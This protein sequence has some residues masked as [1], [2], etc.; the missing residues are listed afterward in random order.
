VHTADELVISSEEKG[1]KHILLVKKGDGVML[2]ARFAITAY[3]SAPIVAKAQQPPIEEALALQGEQLAKAS[4]DV[5]LLLDPVEAEALFPNLV[6]VFGLDALA[7][8]L[9]TTRVVGMKCPGLHSVYERLRLSFTAPD[10]LSPKFDY[11]VSDYDDRFGMLDLDFSAGG[12]TGSAQCYFR[13]AIVEQPCTAALKERVSPDQFE[14]QRA[15][16]IGGSRGLGEYT[17]KLIAAGGG[18][19]VLS[20]RNGEEDAAAVVAEIVAHGAV[21]TAVHI[22]TS[23]AGWTEPLPLVDFTHIYYFASPKIAANSAEFDQ[24]LYASFRKVFVEALKELLNSISDAKA[25]MRVFVPSSIFVST[26]EPNFA[27]YIQAK[28]DMEELCS[29]AAKQN[30]NLIVSVPRLP[31]LRT[32]QTAGLG[33]EAFADTGDALIPLLTEFS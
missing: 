19:V 17:A 3:L 30:N 8:I 13:P 28:A 29:A 14:G 9:A 1:D 25:K 21:A 7:V 31:R 10:D 6:R 33:D 27:E 5:P 15:L 26:P 20:Y 4:G 16:V 32:D 18:E 22:D 11:K 12:V 2:K 24:A 23:Q